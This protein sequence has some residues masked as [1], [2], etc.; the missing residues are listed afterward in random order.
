MAV[1][2]KIA[3]IVCTGGLAGQGVLPFSLPLRLA[4]LS[5]LLLSNIAQFFPFLSQ[6]GIS[7][8]AIC[9]FTLDSS[10]LP[11]RFP[12]IT[13]QVKRDSTTLDTFDSYLLCALFCF[14]LPLTDL[15]VVENV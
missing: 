8:F 12:L 3:S 2:L 4:V 5:P 13:F 7:P 9:R 10:P 1:S 15:L 11:K 14:T 6:P